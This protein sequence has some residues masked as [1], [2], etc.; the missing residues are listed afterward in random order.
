M[1]ILFVS[2]KYPPAVGGMEKQSFEL[3][4]GMKQYA[5]VHAIVYEGGESRFRFFRMLRKRIL[6]TLR[7]NPDIT[8]IHF[9]D[10][11]MAAICAGHKGYEHLLRA[12]T[13]HG[14]EV[15]FP[16]RLYQRYILPRFNRYDLIIAVSRAT[17]EACVQRGLSPEKVVVIPNGVDSVL[18]ET[19]QRPDFKQFMLEKYGIEVE[20]RRILVAMGR[21][22]RR[23]GFS[24]LIRQVVP[25]LQGDFVFLMIGPFQRKPGGFEIFLRYVPAF[26]RRQI[27]LFAGFPT[28]EA[29]IRQLLAAPELQDKVRHLGKLPFEDI[30]QILSAADA[31]LMPNIPIEGDMEG[32]GL[33]CLEACLCGATVFASRLDG[34]TEAIHDG[35]NGVL[36]PAGDA[37]AWASA[38]NVL[39]ENPAVFSARN[40]AAKRYTLE[41]FGWDKMAEAYW[42]HLRG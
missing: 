24:W 5:K 32:F 27:T 4:Q 35:K 10:G 26:L 25:K 3:I 11:L 22:V 41:H 1:E 18:A 7:E 19:V 9:N 30:R 33:V 16:N 13:L 36:L 12:V 6:Q 20:G 21:S 40:D 14:L 15:V 38:L 37:E 29:A 28:D 42:E 31:F 2:H 8:A 23:K 39:M 17:A 34:I